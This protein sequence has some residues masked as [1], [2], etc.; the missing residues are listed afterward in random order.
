MRGW[1]ILILLVLGGLGAAGWYLLWPLA[2]PPPPL[3]PEGIV[4]KCT[5]SPAENPRELELSFVNEGDTPLRFLISHT[6]SIPYDA[7]WSVL[8][9]ALVLTAKFGCSEKWVHRCFHAY[10]VEIPAGGHYRFQVSKLLPP[11]LAQRVEAGSVP[12]RYQTLPVSQF[13]DAPRAPE[14]GEG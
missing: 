12:C 4:V 5:A 7:G 8:K 10:Q 1:L 9:R 13:P 14:A 6:R 3:D 2:P 11:E